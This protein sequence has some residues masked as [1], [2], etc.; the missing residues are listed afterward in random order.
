MP[1]Y[2]NN[3]LKPYRINGHFYKASL[4]KNN[5]YTKST[6]L[7]ELTVCRN[8]FIRINGKGNLENENTFEYRFLYDN[9]GEKYGFK[10]FYEEWKYFFIKEIKSKI[11]LFSEL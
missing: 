7:I 2:C 6:I 3:Q 4:I 10:Y 8:L 9:Y 5:S 1:E 11:I